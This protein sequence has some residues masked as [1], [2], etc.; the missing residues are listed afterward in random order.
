MA[1]KIDHCSWNRDATLRVAV[2]ST[3]VPPDSTGQARVLGHLIGIGGQIPDNRFLI[4][5]DDNPFEP[6]KGPPNY[7]LLQP[8]LIR[9]EETHWRDKLNS[10]YDF[11]CAV[12]KR[13]GE[14][15]RHV[16]EFRSAALVACTA[17]PVDLP[18]STLVAFRRRIPL[19]AYLFDDPVFQWEHR[20]LRTFSS[21]WE[22][23]WSRSAA[24]VVVP[25]EA[26]AEEFFLR[27]G[28]RPVL[29]RNAVS[30]EA[31]SPTEQA[32]PSSPGQFRIVYTG[33]VYHAQ[34]DA[35][36]NLLRALDDVTGWSLHIFTNQSEA[37]LARHGIQG[38]KVF[39]HE[40][41]DL[42][43]SYREQQLAD[44]LFLPLA[45]NSPI[46]EVLRTSA[47]MKMAEYLAS[48]RP[49]LAHVPADT[50]VAR[51]LRQHRAGVLVDKPDIN[52]ITDA[53]HAIST[54]ADL[55]SSLRNNALRLAEEYRIERARCAFWNVV[56]TAIQ[57]DK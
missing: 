29:I 13:A 19:I 6:G 15:S 21:L 54:D 4:L 8:P 26:L 33:S 42:Q 55:R 7:R 39:R 53:L 31:F 52:S 45:F 47:P 16:E 30:P 43:S 46:Q 57:Q 24:Q 18:A 49:I 5:T 41:L 22:A 20:S 14:I 48:G 9:L 44:A 11:L 17:S 51:L 3:S 32:W 38:P 25:N 12:F 50:F 10:A 34:A 2:V 37:T 23:V 36:I 40:P 35:F 1:A 28:R 27:R 56:G